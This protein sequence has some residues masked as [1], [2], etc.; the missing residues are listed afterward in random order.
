M[1]ELETWTLV[2]SV[3]VGVLCSSTVVNAIVGWVMPFPPA[4]A[5]IHNNAQTATKIGVV[6]TVIMFIVS[7]VT[8]QYSETFAAENLQALLL[9]SSI[10]VLIIVFALIVT[11]LRHASWPLSPQRLLATVVLTLL[12]TC[13]TGALTLSIGQ[14]VAKDAEPSSTS[15]Y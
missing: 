2:S 6:C 11:T 3:L 15:P 12:C 7:I 10:L 13:A 5:T 4:Y 1:L 8:A 9:M 14:A